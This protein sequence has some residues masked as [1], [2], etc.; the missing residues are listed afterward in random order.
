MNNDEKWMSLAIKQAVKA[1]TEEEVPVGA[2]L[3]KDGKLIAQA[4]NQPI[5]KNDATIMKTCGVGA[6]TPLGKNA[7][8]LKNTKQPL[9]SN[10]T[11]KT[12]CGNCCFASSLMVAAAFSNMMP[13][14]SPRGCRARSGE[15]GLGTRD[16]TATSKSPMPLTSFP[17]PLAPVLAW[18]CNR[19][20]VWDMQLLWEI[21]YNCYVR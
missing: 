3:V 17:A 6:L 18:P 16:P 14:T 13:G 1:G 10:K 15:T 8:P 12:Q 5:S 20:A 2:V 7:Q 9:F 4:H 11:I 21:S 19:L